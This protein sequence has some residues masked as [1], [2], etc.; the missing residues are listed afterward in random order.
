MAASVTSIR[1]ARSLSP[2][3]DHPDV[4]TALNNLAVLYREQGR[5]SDADVLHKR[6]L[7][8]D[9]GG[10]SLAAVVARDNVQVALPGTVLRTLALGI[11]P[12]MLVADDPGVDAVNEFGLLADAPFARFDPDPVPIAD[13]RL[14]STSRVLKNSIYLVSLP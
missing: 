14:I 6:A 1:R 12:G 11:P 10:A 13:S 8:I 3:P 2:F 5:Y 9:E 7:A 4:A